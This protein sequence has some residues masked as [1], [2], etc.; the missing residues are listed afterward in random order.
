MIRRAAAL[1]LLAPACSASA[2]APGAGADS[3]DLPAG[4]SEVSGLAI[5]STGSVFAHNDEEAVVH[6][7]E[8]ATGRTLRRFSL[9]SPP[10]RGDFE[11]IAAES[12][13]VY[14]ITSDGQLLAAPIGPD[15]ARV[16]FE[17]HD[18]GVGAA[19]EIEGLSL[20]PEPGNLLILCKRA[21]R[22]G[23]E[24]RLLIYQWRIGSTAP[25]RRPW[26]DIE[27][28]E[29]LGGGRR[30]FAPSSIEWVPARRQLV[31]VSAR[32]RML[33]VLDET[34][35]ILGT[36]RLEAARHPQPEGLAVTSSDQLAIADEGQRGRPGRLTV[37][38]P[39]YL[40]QFLS[41]FAAT[42][43]GLPT[44]SKKPAR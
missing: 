37:Y 28:G 38:P 3:R 13:R 17:V 33:L 21:R 23:R 30:Q 32:D 36:R 4:L 35:R 10:A 15:G 7:I 5:A 42:P 1:L 22:G 20:A 16:P 6:E 2:P 18:T 12:G 29:A 40:R 26:R 19:C 14:L 31:V 39:D 34:G 27:L 41:R 9:G 8:L 25:V 44:S 11:G 24:G 43:S